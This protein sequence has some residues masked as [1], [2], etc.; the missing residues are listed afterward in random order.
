MCGIQYEGSTTTTAKPTSPR[1]KLYHKRL[2]V[3]K[4]VVHNKKE[5][6]KQSKIQPGYW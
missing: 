5:E 2:L 6:I 3:L 4:L 1:S